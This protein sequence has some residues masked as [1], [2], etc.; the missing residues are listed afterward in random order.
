MGGKSISCFLLGRRGRVVDCPDFLDSLL[1]PVIGRLQEAAKGARPAAEVLERGARYRIVREILP[2]LLSKGKKK[3]AR[4]TRKA[5]PFGISDHAI[6]TLLLGLSGVIARMTRFPA[7]L[8]ALVGVGIGAMVLLGWFV[9]GLRQT[10]M[11]GLPM[12]GQFMG[13]LA[14]LGAVC[15]LGV[16]GIRL[17]ERQFLK[18]VFTRLKLPPRLVSRLPRAGASE[19]AL[20]LALCA[21]CVGVLF[22]VGPAGVSWLGM[23]GR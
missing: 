17:A 2:I 4:A 13:D 20:I 16:L 3:A 10:A 21:V 14:L 1:R 18:R 5:Y 7:W 11:A 9:F 19:L 12:G 23:I 6:K 15:L 22:W 8:A